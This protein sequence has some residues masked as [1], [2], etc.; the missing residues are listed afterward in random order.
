MSKRIFLENPEIVP[1]IEFGEPVQVKF[2]RTIVTSDFFGYDLP[3]GKIIIQH[4]CWYRPVKTKVKAH[5]ALG[6]VAGYRHAIYGLPEKL[7]PVL[8]EHPDNPDMLISTTPLNTYKEGRFTPKCDWKIVLGRIDAFL[9]GKDGVNDIDWE[10]SVRPAFSAEEVLPENIEITAFNHNAQ[11]TEKNIFFDPEGMKGEIGVFEGYASAIEPNG[12][13]SLRP[14]MRGDCSGE[15]A[16]VPALDWSLNKN[17]ASRNKA[18]GIMNYLF[19]ASELTD[20]NPLS[21][22]Y[23]GIRFYENL[24][25]Y[26][27]SGNMRPIMGCVL[28]SELTDNYQF[29]PNILRCMLSMLRTTGIN[30]FRR[31]RLDNPASFTDAK[32]WKYYQEED[33]VDYQPHYHAA[34]WAGYIQ[35]YALTGHKEFLY[36]A[37]TGI[38]M[39]MDAFPDF[40][41]TNGITQ[42][43]A[44]MLWP[45]AFLIQV[46]DTKQHRKW[47]RTIMDKLLETIVDCG[48]IREM[49]GHPEKGKYPAPRSN[50]EYGASEASLIQENGDSACDLVYTVNYAFIGLHE[51]AFATGEEIYKQAADNMADFL[52]RIQVNSIEQPYLDGC[53]IRGFDYD[54]WDYFGSSSDNGWGVWCVESGWT[55]AWI[56]TT[57]ALR[58]MNRS[59]LCRENSEIYKNLMPELLR[60]MSIVHDDDMTTSDA[61]AQFTAPGSE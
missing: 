13:Q 48:T 54:L 35:A 51:A 33:F 21:P 11:W 3:Q 60:E 12:H 49:M 22:T 52:C 43:Y 10:M 58:T 42:E 45:L 44:R 16:A 18:Y 46:D 41:W 1:G 56:A 39:M 24:P 50:E 26:Y 40:K 25:A 5:L 53:W 37:K 6:R 57:F 8:F 55:N 20:N 59:L 31:R 9:E 47:L 32:T 23:G 61:K 34:T 4:N 7:F 36:K 38:R 30:G 2:E 19:N 15:S 14:K 27:G 17:Y 29:A 28:A